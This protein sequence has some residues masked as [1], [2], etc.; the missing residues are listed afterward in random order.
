MAAV[1]MEKIQ[2]EIKSLQKDV[3]ILKRIVADKQEL[4]DWAKKELKLARDA[5]LKKYSSQKDI[6]R[7]FL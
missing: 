5:P 2:S 1:T 7:E 6:E 4:S 3:A